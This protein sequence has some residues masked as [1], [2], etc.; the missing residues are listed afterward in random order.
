MRHSDLLKAVLLPAALLVGCGQGQPEAEVSAADLQQTEAAL[1]TTSTPQLLAQVENDGSLRVSATHIY[2]NDYATIRRVP[3]AGGPAETALSAP[4]EGWISREFALDDQYI[5]AVVIEGPDAFGH[6]VRV[7]LAGG[8]PENLLGGELGYPAIAVDATHVYLASSDQVVR[9]PKDG[10]LFLAPEI[11]A[12]AQNNASSIA[13]DGSNVYWIDMGSPN[14]ANGCNPWEGKI[15]AWNK[16]TGTTRLLASGENCPLNLV[17]DGSSLYWGN[18]ASELRKI[19]TWSYFGFPQTVAREV[20]GMAIA[21]DASYLYA[22]AETDEASYLTA[23]G[24]F[25]GTRHI[26]S[27]TREEPDSR[28]SGLA[29]DAQ[30]LYYL[31]YDREIGAAGL[32]KLRK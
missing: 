3:K 12:S 24:K 21:A 14:P 1:I 23:V 13:V 7:P 25:F 2:V 30:N 20:Y 31:R 29:A 19:S 9:F 15:R 17:L 8:R 6:V 28:M 27:N 10:Q 18:Y 22:L 26:F 4:L 32:Y 16:L 11:I 5:Y